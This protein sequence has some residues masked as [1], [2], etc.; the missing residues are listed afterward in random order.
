MI[1][2]ILG[3]ASVLG[4]ILGSKGAS[5]AARAQE[6]AA[7]QQLEL[8]REMFGR[9]QEF[10]SPYQQAG[11]EGQ[12]ELMRLLG[13]RGEATS[14]GY[15]SLTQPFSQTQFE[16]DPGY[17]FRMAEG[18]KALER[19]AAARGGLLSGAALKGIQRYG[20]DLASQ[21]YQNAFQR[22][23]AE[24]QARYAPLQ[25]LM[26]SGQQAAG[27]LSGAAG[28]FG[29]AG[30]QALADVGAARA[31]GYV[32]QTNAFQ[33]ALAG[34]VNALQYGL[35]MRQPNLQPYEITGAAATRM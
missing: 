10:L 35:A 29:A 23:Q 7:Q 28:G 9:Q 27:A 20:Q 6:R 33:Q 12:N 16:A 13:L 17:G 18:M 30:G 34:G 3:A 5:S 8:Q 24:R 11:L 14:A 1:P 15:G 4:G 21:E 31:S 2:L 26:A 19:S 25:N 32:G 22:Y